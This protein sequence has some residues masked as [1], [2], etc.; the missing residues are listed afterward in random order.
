MAQI[1]RFAQMLKV[2][3]RRV[4][5]RIVAHE[6]VEGSLLAENIH[7]GCTAIETR[8]DIES[9]AEPERLAMVL[10]NAHNVCIVGNTVRNGVQ[11][12]NTFLVNGAAFDPAGY[13]P[14]NAT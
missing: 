2:D 6:A 5:A 9:D 13:P 7:G 11:Q 1:E 8:F 4:S 14:L 10:R 12:E 3:I